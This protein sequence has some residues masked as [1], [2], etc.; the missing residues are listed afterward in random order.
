M[1][2][3]R[4]FTRAL[5]SMTFRFLMEIA[6]VGIDGIHLLRRTRQ[7]CSAVGIYEEAYLRV[8]DIQ[9]E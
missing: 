9:L 6:K 1:L 5:P 3:Y 8:Q 7:I 4:S 2:V